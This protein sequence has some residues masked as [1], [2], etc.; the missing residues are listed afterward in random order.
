MLVKQ[1]FLIAHLSLR[2]AHQAEVNRLCVTK[3][4]QWQ[5]VALVPQKRLIHH[6]L[7]RDEVQV[8]R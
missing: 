4:E 1:D 6:L 8:Y 2:L 3:H 7:F 5:G